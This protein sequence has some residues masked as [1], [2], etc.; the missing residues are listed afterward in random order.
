MDDYSKTISFISYESQ[1][2]ITSTKEY[3]GFYK[4]LI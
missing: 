2:F 3:E 1:S 4:H